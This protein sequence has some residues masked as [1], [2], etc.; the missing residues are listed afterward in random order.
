VEASPNRIVEPALPARSGCLWPRESLGQARSLASVPMAA[1]MAM[2]AVV[3]MPGSLPAIARVGVSAPVVLA[4]CVRIELGAP[5]G[6]VMT[7]CADAGP[8]RAGRINNAT[9]SKIA[10][11]VIAASLSAILTAIGRKG[12]R[13][14]WLSNQRAIRYQN[15]GCLRGLAR[16]TG[17]Q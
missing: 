16:S 10:G 6:L 15:S 12:S 9:P 2:A 1:V 5:P 8:A 3:T 4:I 7:C 14:D 17:G 11:L 13:S